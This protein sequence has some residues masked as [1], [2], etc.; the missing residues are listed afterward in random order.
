V[1]G[2]LFAEHRAASILPGFI[3]LFFNQFAKPT[4]RD[5]EICGTGTLHKLI[6]TEDAVN[7]EYY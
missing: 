5:R 6:I 4:G 3:P 7:Y 2:L 1:R